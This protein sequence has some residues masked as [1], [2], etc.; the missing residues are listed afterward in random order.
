MTGRAKAGTRTARVKVVRADG[1]VVVVRTMGIE[2]LGEPEPGG[3]DYGYGQFV[4]SVDYLVMGRNSYEKVM[5][6][7]ERRFKRLPILV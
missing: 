2:W 7:A 4:E 3:E 1:K 5:S 6:L